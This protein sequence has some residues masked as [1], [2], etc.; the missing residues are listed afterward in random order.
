M[1]GAVMSFELGNDRIEAER[2][3]RQESAEAECRSYRRS[4]ECELGRTGRS[5]GIQIC[6]PTSNGVVVEHRAI[7]RGLEV[8]HGRRGVLS[9]K[10]GPIERVQYIETEDEPGDP[11]TRHARPEHTPPQAPD[12]IIQTKV[13]GASGTSADPK[14]ALGQIH[15]VLFKGERGGAPDTDTVA[16]G[17]IR[18]LKARLTDTM[19]DKPPSAKP[20]S[21]IKEW[22]PSDS[23]EKVTRTPGYPEAR[24]RMSVVDNS[25]CFADNSKS[26]TSIGVSEDGE[27]AEQP[28]APSTSHGSRGEELEGKSGSGGSDTKDPEGSEGMVEWRKNIN[29]EGKGEAVGEGKEEGGDS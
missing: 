24:V 26:A 20:T 27:F 25:R 28:P 17:V 29:T 6:H 18:D 23:L 15:R 2:R 21:G 1:S 3:L 5:D 11:G 4:P 22:S 14:T 16:G 13:P 7:L 12:R 8:R 10:Q 9:L 19:V